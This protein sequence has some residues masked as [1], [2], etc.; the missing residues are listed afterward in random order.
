MALL[1]ANMGLDWRHRPLHCE[2]SAECLHPDTEL[3]PEGPKVP[4]VGIVILDNREGDE[5]V[6][7][8]EFGLFHNFVED[9]GN[10]CR[11]IPERP[12]TEGPQHQSIVAVGKAD[13]ENRPNLVPGNINSSLGQTAISCQFDGIS[14][15]EVQC[16]A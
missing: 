12:A 3:L 8:L 13:A 7:V 16:G 15:I 5:T 14:A 4:V 11:R 10:F 1:Q 2:Y 6:L 9:S